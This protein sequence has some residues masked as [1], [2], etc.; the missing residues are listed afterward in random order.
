[1]VKKKQ[2]ERERTIQ[3]K[4]LSALLNSKISNFTP[5]SLGMKTEK[6]DIPKCFYKN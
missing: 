4:T 5:S 6:E 1:M 3:D 2:E